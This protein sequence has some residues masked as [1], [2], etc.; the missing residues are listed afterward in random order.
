MEVMETYPTRFGD[1]M[2]RER[3]Q[4]A[5]REAV[6]VYNRQLAIDKLGRIIAENFIPLEDLFITL[7]YER[8]NRPADY[9]AA[10]KDRERFI[11]QLKKEYKRLGIEL[12]LIKTTAYGERG[13]VHHH[14][15]IPKGIRHRDVWHIWS[16]VIGASVKA[17]PPEVRTLYSSG[18]YSSLAAYFVDQFEK[19][20]DSDKMRNKRRWICSRN[21]KRPKEEPPREIEEIKWKEPPVARNGYYIDTDSIRAGT[22]LVNGRPY[23]FYRMI[24]LPPDFSCYDKDSGKHL[25][26]SDAI[27]HFRRNNRE[28]IKANKDKL[29]PE[30][31]IVL[32]NIPPSR[33]EPCHLPLGQ[34]RHPNEKDN[35]G[36]RQD[37]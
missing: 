7:T 25:K 18:E 36:V 11:Y 5:T 9:D 19:G 27:R 2:T 13:A 35:K 31:E 14:L 6:A 1:C 12:K 3:P 26:G 28:W 22:N 32:R 30:G 15:I 24:K 16:A 21:I 4:K 20:A 34:G 23:L 10:V 33:Q 37:E 17:R 8:H 29:F